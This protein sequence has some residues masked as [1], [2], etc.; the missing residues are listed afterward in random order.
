MKAT[1]QGWHVLGQVTPDGFKA[2]V[3]GI[4]RAP[5]G[6]RMLASRPALDAQLTEGEAGTVITGAIVRKFPTK[7]EAFTG[8]YV[9]PPMLVAAAIIALATPSERPLMIG[10]IV[11]SVVMLLAARASRAALGRNDEASQRYLRGWLIHFVEGTP[12]PTAETR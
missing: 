4:S 9:L 5:D 6:T 1:A 10:V 11:V 2:T 3:V 8:R 12:D 7:R